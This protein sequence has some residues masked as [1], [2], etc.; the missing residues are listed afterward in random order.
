MIKRERIS[1]RYCQGIAKTFSRKAKS[2]Q[3]LNDDCEAD[4]D[5]GMDF[6]VLL[7]LFKEGTTRHP[8]EKFYA[9]SVKFT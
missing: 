3:N 4:Q 5:N 9:I 7:Q 2:Q 8:H 1:R 6:H